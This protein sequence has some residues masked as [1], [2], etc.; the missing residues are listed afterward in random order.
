MCERGGARAFDAGRQASQ[1]ADM[2]GRLNS[3]QT[4]VLAEYTVVTRAGNQIV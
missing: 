1:Q 3:G 4:V 2:Y